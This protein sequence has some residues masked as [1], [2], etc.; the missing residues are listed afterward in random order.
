MNCATAQN[1]IDENC[2][3][4]GL[5]WCFFKRDQMQTVK[6]TPLSGIKTA[7]TQQGTGPELISTEPVGV[8]ALRENSRSKTVATD[9]SGSS[10][11]TQPKEKSWISSFVEALAGA[12]ML[13]DPEVINKL[14]IESKP[15]SS[16]ERT[17]PLPTAIVST[18]PPKG[19]SDLEKINEQFIVS[20]LKKG[21][22]SLVID[23]VTYRV[24]IDKDKSQIIVKKPVSGKRSERADWRE[25]IC[26]K[27]R[28]EL[29]AHR[30]GPRGLPKY[31]HR[32]Y[33]SNRYSKSELTN[34]GPYD[35]TCKDKT[36]KPLDEDL[37]EEAIEKYSIIKSSPLAINTSTNSVV[38]QPTAPQD[39]PQT[40]RPSDKPDSR[41]QQTQ[42]QIKTTGQSSESE[43]ARPKK[44]A[45]GHS[46]SAQATRSLQTPRT[47]SQQTQVKLKKNTATPTS[48][49]SRLDASVQS[50]AKKERLNTSQSKQ[51]TLTKR[52]TGR[53]LSNQKIREITGKIEPSVIKIVHFDVP[54]GGSIGESQWQ[55]IRNIAGS[56]YIRVAGVV[57]RGEFTRNKYETPISVKVSLRNRS[58]KNESQ[59]QEIENELGKFL[60]NGLY[61]LESLQGTGY[62][63]M[64]KHFTFDG[65][66]DNQFNFKFAGR[67]YQVNW[68]HKDPTK[69]TVSGGPKAQE[70][71]KTIRKME[72]PKHD[73]IELDDLANI[74]QSFVRALQQS[75]GAPKI[76]FEGRTYSVEFDLKDPFK[77]QVRTE[78]DQ[79]KPDH[80]SII[81]GKLSERLYDLS[82]RQMEIDSVK[83][84][85]SSL[86]LLPV[87]LS[88]DSFSENNVDVKPLSSI[89][90]ALEDC[91]AKIN[92]RR[93]Y[94]EK[95]L[96]AL[97]SSLEKRETNRY[98]FKTALLQYG[99]KIKGLK[100]EIAVLNAAHESTLVIK[101]MLAANRRCGGGEL[102]QAIELRIT[103]MAGKLG[104]ICSDVNMNAA[105]RESTITQLLKDQGDANVFWGARRVT[106]CLG[107]LNNKR[108][109][110]TA[111]FANLQKIISDP[112]ATQEQILDRIDSLA[113]RQQL[114]V[115][116]DVIRPKLKSEIEKYLKTNVY[117]ATPDAQTAGSVSGRT[118]YGPEDYER[119]GQLKTML[120]TLDKKP[121][122]ELAKE[123]EMLINKFNLLTLQ[124]DAATRNISWWAKWFRP[125]NVVSTDNQPS[126]SGPET[127]LPSIT[128]RPDSTP[129]LNP[130]VSP[131]PRT[132][133]QMEASDKSI[134]NKQK[135]KN[136]A[137]DAST[138]DN[139]VRNIDYLNGK[140]QRLLQR[141]E[142]R[143]KN[144]LT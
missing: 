118:Y 54:T 25:R 71:L 41:P 117:P 49:K 22:Q 83:D 84:I 48:P 34:S 129:R 7:E 68:N 100:Q 33:Y 136:K 23:G 126:V 111:E 29:I 120:K 99:S 72:F 10:G 11:T 89:G 40:P 138:V 134:Q 76:F 121:V 66:L 132:P 67:G 90:V 123:F 45:K 13:D 46:A 106:I 31:L 61:N 27:V 2:S 18:P 141:Q 75:K 80:C 110:S 112:S 127:S 4:A 77:V 104:A 5:D 78:S 1:Q 70:I 79:S 63:K 93:A 43:S 30:H 47:G 103:A 19:A 142:V 38:V 135:Q 133:A 9:L 56:F 109:K 16:T 87:E 91:C 44:R 65:R 137:K 88:L 17:S 15:L 50:N 86:S 140:A 144:G 131:T 58:N 12:G 20:L 108:L 24:S 57:Y 119:I 81:Q 130:H 125:G 39:I 42:T 6:N 115:V 60:V 98:E 143:E 101:G 102:G 128:P 82:S 28:E 95:E 114:L 85:G 74:D 124:I 35:T 122:D 97:R 69:I 53:G 8:R 92:T 52:A 14:S 36:S 73:T 139:D 64:I 3:Y 59:S 51:V 55:K 94:V 105:N 62:D 37:S 26:D 113:H 116:D 107:L 32:A 96:K 21:P